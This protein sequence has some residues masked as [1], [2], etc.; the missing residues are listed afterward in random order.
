MKFSP[1]TIVWDIPSLHVKTTKY[2]VLIALGITTICA[3]LS[4]NVPAVF[5]SSIL[6]SGPQDYLRI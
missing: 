3:G 5:L 6:S 1:F 2:I 4:Y